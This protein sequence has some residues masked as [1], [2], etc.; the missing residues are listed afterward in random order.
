[1]CKFVCNEKR[2][3]NVDIQ[4]VLCSFYKNKQNVREPREYE[5][6]LVH[7]Y[8]STKQI[9]SELTRTTTKNR[10]RREACQE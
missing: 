8:T 5:R 2:V 1:M 3:N 4:S 7:C 10:V 9:V 6:V